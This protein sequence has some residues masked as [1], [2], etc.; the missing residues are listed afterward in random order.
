M[1]ISELW[2]NFSWPN[3]CVIGVAKVEEGTEKYLKK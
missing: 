3:G 2:N 1:F